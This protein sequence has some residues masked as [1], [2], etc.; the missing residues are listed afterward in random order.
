MLKCLI[1]E[2]SLR[3]GLHLNFAELL[4]SIE[5]LKFEQRRVVCKC[6]KKKV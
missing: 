6:L 5:Y 4:Y 2:W 1:I 3:K